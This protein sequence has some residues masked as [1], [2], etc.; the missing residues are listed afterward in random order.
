MTT[1]FFSILIPTYNRATLLQRAINSVLN[2]TFK[3]YEIIIVNDGSTKEL[4]AYSEIKEKYKTYS[5]IFFIDKENGGPSSTR[6]IGIQNAQGEFICF[7]DDDDYY[8]ENHLMELHELISANKQV[9]GLYRT[10]S[11]FLEKDTKLTPQIFTERNKIEHPVSY[12]LH[13]LIIPVNICINKSVFNE[14]RFNQTLRVAEDYELWVRILSKYPIFE[15]HI[16]TTVYD[17]TRETAST[18]SVSVFLDYI[19]SFDAIFKLPEAKNII[20]ESFKVN[21]FKKYFNW[22]VADYLEKNEIAEFKKLRSEIIKRVGW[23]FYIYHYVRFLKKQL[24]KLW[25]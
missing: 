2:Q 11:Y 9:T 13:K 3:D 15:K 14:Y 6:N 1:S 21:K 24:N 23:R 12:I 5:N 7:L 17:R 10:F 16:H 8:L 22:I 18:G 19:A 25:D 20:S 4:D